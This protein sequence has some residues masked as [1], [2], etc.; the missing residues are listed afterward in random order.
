MV[1]TV[2]WIQN[3]MSCGNK[4]WYA[5]LSLLG[6][7]EHEMGSRHW[8]DIYM[9]ELLYYRIPMI[10]LLSLSRKLHCL[11]ATRG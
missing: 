5:S 3:R 1:E 4:N 7:I 10:C 9:P 2:E 11:E 6:I 8:R